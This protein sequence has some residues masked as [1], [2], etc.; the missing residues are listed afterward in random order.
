MRLLEQY[1]KLVVFDTET[2]GLIYHKDEIIEFSAAVVESVGGTPTITRE[3][4]QL[5]SLSP[6]KL[7][8]PQIQQLTG[9]S[10]QDLRE[11]G[12]PKTRACR[13]IA[14]LFQG[15]RTLLLAY[16]A[17]FDLSFLF[18]ALA[19]DGDPAILKGRDKLD[20]LTVYRDRQS[21][22]HRLKNAIEAYRLTDQVQNTH[23]AIDD[24]KENPS[25]PSSPQWKWW[26]WCS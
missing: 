23:R 24:V 25:T 22:P 16:N 6:G 19:R 20:L 21:Y 9:I 14:E 10:T 11:R 26:E 13:D 1:R 4:D 8:P 18:Y 7:V 5:I 3:Y 2:T 17:H 15:E 12:I